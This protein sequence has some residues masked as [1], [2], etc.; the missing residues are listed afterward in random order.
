MSSIQRSL[1]TLQY[2]TGTQNGV[3]ITEFASTQRSLN[4][5][6]YYTGT[7][8][9]VLITE[10]S[11]TQ[12]CVERLHFVPYYINSITCTVCSNCVS[13]LCVPSEVQD[14]TNLKNTLLSVL[15]VELRGRRIFA[16]RIKPLTQC[17]HV[18]SCL[19]VEGSS[20]WYT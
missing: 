9:G 19:L 10:V 14:K 18:F 8:N 13:W 2:Y 7:Q 11:S 16:K 4:I 3:L 6:Q 1:N 17:F 15:A 12:S 5:L 20:M